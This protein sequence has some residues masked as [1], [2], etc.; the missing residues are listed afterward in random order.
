MGEI[1]PVDLSQIH[2]VVILGE[3]EWKACHVD[4]SYLVMLSDMSRLFVC[5]NYEAVLDAP[6]GPERDHVMAAT[7]CYFEMD[8]EVEENNVAGVWRYTG[9]TNWL[10]VCGGRA[11]FGAK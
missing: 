6:E 8:V 2:P 10:S 5:T 7:C 1:K 3:K 4:G 9:D 11:A